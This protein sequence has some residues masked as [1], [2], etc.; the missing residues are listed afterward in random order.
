[1][2]ANPTSVFVSNS[3]KRCHDRVEAYAN[4]R[5]TVV[6][7]EIPEPTDSPQAQDEIGFLRALCADVH[8]A[9]YQQPVMPFCLLLSPSP[10]EN[11]SINATIT[12][13]CLEAGTID[14]V[15][16]PLRDEDLHRLVGHIKETLRPAAHLL[17]A[18]MAQ[19][20]VDSIRSVT[21]A[22]VARHRPDQSVSEER[23]RA[24]E[25]AVSI[26]SF[27]AQHFSMDELTYGALYMLEHILEREELAQFRIPRSEL[28]TFLLAARRQYKHS[29]EVHYHNWRHAV[30]VTQS[31]YCFLLDI[32]LIRPKEDRKLKQLNAVERLLTTEDA[33]VLLVSAIGHDVGHPG[34]NNAFLVACNHPLAQMYNDKSVLENYHCAAYSQ[35]IR[36]HWP[37][38]T[39][40]AGFRSLMISN[41]LA[42]DMQRHFE[43]M[44]NM[45]ELQRKVESSDDELQNW[46]DKDCEYARELILALLMKAADISNVARPFDVSSEWA[47]ILM[48]EFARQGEL[49]NE[50]GIPTCLFGGPP[51]R[52]DVLAAAQSQKG[53]M[54]LFGIPLFSGMHEIMPSVSCAGPELENNMAIWDRKIEH[55]KKRRDDHGDSAPLTFSSVSRKEVD[56]AK[57]Q[58]HRSEPLAV[59][60]DA[61]QDSPER[62]HPVVESALSPP[63]HPAH[64]QR[65][66]LTTGLPNAHDQRA[67][68]PYLPPPQMP[69]SPSGGSRRSS[70]DVALDSLQQMSA[71][72]HNPLSPISSTSS[73]RGSA[74]A[75]W[76]VHQSYPGSRRGSKDE[77]LTTILVTSQGSPRR[78]SPGSPGTT[79]RATGS[80][81][82]NTRKRMSMQGS[83][84]DAAA[85]RSSF[86]SSRSH[87]TSSATAAT[88]Q[89]SHSP[90]TQPSSLAATDDEATPPA[91]AHHNSIAA[92]EDPFLV[93][94]N[95]PDDLDGAHRA[96]APGA[97][98]PTTPPLGAQKPPKSD[99]P[100]IIARMASGESEENGRS[101]QRNQRPMIRESRSR[102]RLRGLKFWKKKRDVSSVE[103]GDS[104][105]P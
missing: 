30:D 44:N 48:N 31:L 42:T 104:G 59:P 71:F 32:R 84:P 74:D 64:Q 80:P 1:M 24:V 55:E 87:A 27:P 20:L 41:I 6:L 15:H 23:R 29:R 51:N 33:L 101:S 7:I 99:S 77:S 72:T 95:W 93:P 97:L 22:K 3:A 13:T 54:N 14:L 8:G 12:A 91:G 100:R 62:R 11:S 53:F 25:K 26:W 86:P 65:E 75:S 103:T 28:M 35:L 56:E 68:A 69:L 18:S 5:P 4:T 79:P 61:V 16:R 43:Y 67:S 9:R 89:P 105:S 83:K 88:T 94:G 73:R 37:S 49:E 81:N 21:P 58:H 60:G 92:T 10:G 90:S 2:L 98:P 19:N 34:V 45:S 66:H 40:M 36:R 39:T 76:Q 46:N 52:E 102:S 82:K 70:K 78:S 38:L 85:A 47:K 63:S 96:S 57:M 50:L 17:G